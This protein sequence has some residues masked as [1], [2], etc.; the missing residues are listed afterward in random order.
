MN[1]KVSMSQAQSS[2]GIIATVVLNKV[3][4]LLFAYVNAMMIAWLIQ[5]RT[6][7]KSV[8]AVVAS[9]GGS[10]VGDPK[11]GKDVSCVVAEAE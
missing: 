8:V 7:F 3:G 5:R 11:A 2:A 4:L 10:E 9:Q 1:A 6:D